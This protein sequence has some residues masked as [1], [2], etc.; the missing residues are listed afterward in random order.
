MKRVQWGLATTAAVVVGLAATAI[1][2]T[3]RAEGEAASP[4]DDTLITSQLIL[5]DGVVI[6]EEYQ[7]GAQAVVDCLADVGVETE[8][9]FDDPNGHAS[10]FTPHAVLTDDY[11][12]QKG[13]CFDMH[14][15]ENVSLGW[16]AALG[17][18]DLGELR[19]ET[20]AVTACVE[21]RTGQT[22]GEPTYDEFGYLTEQGRQTRDA[23]FEYQDHEPWDRCHNDLGYLEEYKAE[24]EA[25]ESFEIGS[26]W[27]AEAWESC[28]L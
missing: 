27:D 2:L 6:K 16:A 18:L 3:V 1:L 15:S 4:K 21:E 5:E 25:E 10:F 12:K 23:A 22:F 28:D 20:T 7:A 9:N 13:G 14:L 19:D 26:C 8:V 17:Q 11:V 24:T